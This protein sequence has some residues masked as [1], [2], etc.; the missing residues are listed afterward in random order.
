[1]QPFIYQR[2]ETLEA[3][4][5]AAA[6]S[7]GS[8]VEAPVQF[9]AGGT[10]LLDL[11]KI[12]VMRPATVVDINP[13][14]ERY[15]AIATDDKGL[16]LGALARMAQVA[17]HPSV[18]RDFPVIAQTLDL[19]ASQQLRNMATLGGNLLQRT[20]CNYFR[21]VSWAA[22]NKRNPGSGC[23][24]LDGMNRKHA[25][26]GT[27]DQCIATYPGDFAQ[28]LVALDATLEIAGPQ[29]RREI[30]VQQ[31]HK[32]PGSTPNIETQLVPGELITAILVPSAPWT[33][34][35][36]Y[37]KV[38]DRE[39][40]EFA[41]ASAAV[42]LDIA[43]GEVREARIALGGV[44]TMPWRAKEAEAAL[45]GRRLDEAAAEAA[46]EAAFA[47][48]QTHEHNAYKVPLGRRT[49]VRALLD[50]ARLEIRS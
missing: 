47:G 18:R 26:L 45:R 39:S 8:H 20:R 38:R 36:L 42:A 11:M 16:R 1:M 30:A 24:A 37:L 9:V 44:A 34:R 7:R 27:S 14:Q 48:A 49:L 12:D 28:A 17:D 43:D 31:L 19:A 15:G 33:R 41:L 46:A 23:A 29:G 35:S 50:A 13:L 2:A 21:D 10:T 4:A 22:C 6:A 3:A 25:V 5:Q 32:Q 40:Y